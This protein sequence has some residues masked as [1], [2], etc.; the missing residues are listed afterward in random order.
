[1]EHSALAIRS[2]I[3]L[4]NLESSCPGPIRSPRLS[5]IAQTR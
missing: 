5:R 2:Y 3:D 4:D 1:M